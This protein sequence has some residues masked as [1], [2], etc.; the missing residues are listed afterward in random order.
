MPTPY[1][2]WVGR[3]LVWNHVQLQDHVEEQDRVKREEQLDGEQL[4][5]AQLLL[6]DLDEQ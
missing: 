3:Y 1:R 2:H 5:I 6:L 4:G